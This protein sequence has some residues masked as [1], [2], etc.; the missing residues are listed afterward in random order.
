LPDAGMCAERR[1]LRRKIVLRA[2]GLCAVVLPGALLQDRSRN[3]LG[4]GVPCV[5]QDGDD[6]V[7]DKSPTLARG[8]CLRSA[9]KTAASRSATLLPTCIQSLLHGLP[10]AAA[11]R[12]TRT[13]V[14]GLPPLSQTATRTSAT[15]SANPATKPATRTAATRSANPATRRA[16]GRLVHTYKTESQTCYRDECYT[17][18]RPVVEKKMVPVCCGEWQTVTETVPGRDGT[19]P[20]RSRPLGM[21]SVA[22]AAA[23]I[24][25]AAATW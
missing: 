11:R 8:T 10:I 16:I 2:A 12:A 19:V 6:K 23:C 17:C 4:E 18:C 1:L 14:N 20:V 25:P 22:R 21:G 13:S 5:L 7:C 3:G 15:R 24:T 9:T